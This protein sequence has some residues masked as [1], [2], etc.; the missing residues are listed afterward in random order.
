MVRELGLSISASQLFNIRSNATEYISK[1][2]QRNY[3]EV[4]YDKIVNEV[5]LRLLHSNILLGFNYE[6]FKTIY[7]EADIQSEI[8]VQFTN[9]ELIA[10]LYHL[11]SDGYLIYLVSDF[12]LPKDIISKIIE[13]HGFLDL[14]EDVF[15]SC[16]V[17][18]SKENGSIYDD[19]L[20][21]LKMSP[22]KVVMVGDNMQSDVINAEKR[23]LTSIHLNH[24]S[25]KLRNKQNILGKD[26][27][28]FIKACRHVEKACLKSKYAFSEYITHFYFFTERLY[29]NA[30]KNKIKD[31]FFLAREGHYLKELFD[32]YQELH[33]FPQESRIN[34]HYL[35]ASRQSATQ[36]ALKPIEEEEFGLS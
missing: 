11:K 22:D 33:Q 13:H 15:I 18:A 8:A 9:Q 16:S 31:L 10:E 20:Q 23:G 3:L 34:T 12:Y 30:R 1:K 21:C 4:D 2:E 24:F 19:V 29:I 28:S 32:N 5:F 35:K 7:S 25:H 17:N 6:R 36:L 26:Q 14:F 27:E